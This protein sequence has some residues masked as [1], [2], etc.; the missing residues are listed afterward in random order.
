[1]FSQWAV[2]A[3]K[4]AQLRN[5]S[6]SAAATEAAPSEILTKCPETAALVS[7]LDRPAPDR[8]RRD[9]AI[10]CGLLRLG[11]SKEDIWPLVA[12]SSKFESNGRPY[13]DITV[14]NAERTVSSDEIA[15][16]QPRA[17]T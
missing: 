12:G 2:Q 16:C 17:L 8:S 10:V 3:K 13:F 5:V 14:A 4:N 15:L 1:M 6:G 9:F 11:L 7:R